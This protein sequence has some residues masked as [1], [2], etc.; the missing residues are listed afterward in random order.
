MNYGGTTTLTNSIIA[1]SLVGGDCGGAGGVND[2]GNNF[3]GDP[4]CFGSSTITPG[5][6]FDT[7]LADN[8]GPTLTHALLAGS[9]A[10]DAGACDLDFDQRGV[11][12]DSGS[13]E[14]VSG[15]DSDGDGDGVLDNVDLCPG[16]VIPEGV[17]TQRLG[18]NRFV[19][20]DGDG[21]FDTTP[22][23]GGGGGPGLS[24]S[25]EDTAGCSCEQIIE[26]LALGKGHEKFG[27]SISAMETW[28]DL[29]P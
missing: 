11:P 6:D 17:P 27:C 25:I 22:P 9:V 1:N 26:L 12:C 18:V 14:F 13:Y 15:S 2:S 5:V 4:S 19:L 29:V 24:F 8:G 16:T 23:P 21:V 28:V 7:T 3:G 20:V 10:I